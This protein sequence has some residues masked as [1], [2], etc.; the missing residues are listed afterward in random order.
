MPNTTDSFAVYVYAGFHGQTSGNS[1]DFKH[2]KSRNKKA[3][4]PPTGHQHPKTN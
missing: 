3:T 2:E 4:K 1:Y